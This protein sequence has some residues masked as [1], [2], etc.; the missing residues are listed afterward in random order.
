MQNWSAQKKNSADANRVRTQRPESQPNGMKCILCSPCAYRFWFAF[1]LF[2]LCN[3]FVCVFF[4]SQC[5]GRKTNTA[6]MP[7]MMIH[8]NVNHASE[9]NLFAPT[10]C[11][12]R[13]GMTKNTVTAHRERKASEKT[14]KNIVCAG[15]QTYTHTAEQQVSASEWD[16]AQAN[17]I[18]PT[19][20]ITAIPIFFLC[21]LIWWWLH[22]IYCLRPYE[23][24]SITGVCGASGKETREFT[25]K[26][27]NRHTHTQT[28][29]MNLERC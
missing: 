24:K 19:T 3:H 7:I 20:F 8:W 22:I 2:A 23:W 21:S 29:R 16:D 1:V 18:E 12:S 4:V 15:L 5:S 17:Q 25:T 28:P 27:I 26:T 13:N 6:H 9:E 11:W 10:L 14:R